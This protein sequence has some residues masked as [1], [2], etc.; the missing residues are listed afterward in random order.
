MAKAPLLG[1]LGSSLDHQPRVFSKG[2]YARLTKYAEVQGRAGL[3]TMS[4]FDLLS[5]KVAMR[6][7]P[8]GC[9][10]AAGNRYRAL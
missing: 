3:L 8:A 9:V 5:P 10:F 4:F 7:D 2:L 1:Y 6:P